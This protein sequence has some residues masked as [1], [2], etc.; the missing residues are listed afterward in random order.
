MRFAI[1]CDENPGDPGTLAGNFVERDENIKVA[2]ALQQALKRCNQDVWFDDIIT[3]QTRVARANSDG[4]NVLV[5]CA[6][7]ASDNPN[8][9]GSVF[10]FSEGGLGFGRQYQAAQN[11][12]AE[13]VNAG[14]VSRWG[15]YVEDVY[16]CCYFNHDTVY[17]ELMF[18]TNARDAQRMRQPGYHTDAAEAICRGLAKTYGFTYA[19]VRPSTPAGPFWT[20]FTGIA[21]ADPL[22]FYSAANTQSRQLYIAH[23]GNSL[24]FDGWMR[25]ESQTDVILG[26]PDNRWY[27]RSAP[28]FGWTASAW[29][30]GN[31]PESTPS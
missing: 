6:H 20:H 26:T 18:Q 16:E 24:E 11:V 22:P 30:E 25:G 23:R 19:P 29:V 12:G 28:Y 7:N 31:A 15:T 1:S 5:A 2:T 9:E 10:V 13:L 3:F 21:V 8:A 14:V 27:H 4:S 17:C